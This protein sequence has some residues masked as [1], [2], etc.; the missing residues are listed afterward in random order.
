MA[1]DSFLHLARP[2]GPVQIGTQPST[3]PLNVSVQPQAIFAILDH[4]LR[5]PQDQERVIGTLL[6]VRSEDGTEVEI[7]NCYAVPHTETQEQVEVDMDYQKQM[8]QL[9]L[10]ANPKEVL[11]GWYATS[12]DLNTFSALIQNFYG[13]QGD[14]TWPHPAIHLTVSTVPGKDIEAK[15]YISAPVGVTAERAADSCLFIPVPHEIKYGE[16]DRSGL[17]LISG[18]KDREDR[19]QM[20]QT[21]IDTLERAIEQVLEMID[22]VSNYVSNVLDEEAEPSS[23]LGQFLMNTL[24]LAPKVDAEDIERDLYVLLLSVSCVSLANS[25]PAATTTSKT[26]SLSHTSPTP[27]APKSTCQT[28]SQ[29]PPSPWAPRPPPPK[30]P[31][32]RATRTKNVATTTTKTA[33]NRTAPPPRPRRLHPRRLSLFHKTAHPFH[34]YF[35][36]FLCSN[37][38]G[39]KGGLSQST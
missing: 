10:R 8:L 19:S 21:D 34:V 4:S 7:R 33:V 23:A 15:T 38:S 39:K 3:A 6:G 17:E 30:S 16:A 24:S 14:G 29:L 32:R 2:L 37:T 18:A 25:V 12:S 11:L 22:R 9:H 13:Q 1:Q 27:S 36:L 5:R 31:A 28:V 35:N 20:L 26:F